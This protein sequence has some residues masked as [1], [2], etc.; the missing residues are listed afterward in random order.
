MI[1]IWNVI[2]K[3]CS[4][5]ASRGINYLQHTNFLVARD[6]LKTIFAINS[7]NLNLTNMIYKLV[8]MCLQC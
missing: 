7:L 5:L 8:D 1:Q 6:N 3:I 2:F 4:L